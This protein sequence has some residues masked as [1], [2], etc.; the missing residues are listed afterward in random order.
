MTAA[1]VACTALRTLWSTDP[2]AETQTELDAITRAE[3]FLTSTL[4]ARLRDQARQ[5][6]DFWAEIEAGQAQATAGCIVE[7]DTED[8]PDD[9]TGQ[10]FLAITERLA[11]GSTSLISFRVE[12]AAT[13]QPQPAGPARWL[14]S[15][16]GP[17][18]AATDRTN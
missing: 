4:T 13:A 3:P 14:I 6:S 2:T 5:P 9:W 7:R 10:L 1:E 16:I 11:D 18:Q 12:A 15:H 8:G 17:P